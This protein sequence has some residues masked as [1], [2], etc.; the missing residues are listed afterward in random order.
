MKINELSV[1]VQLPF[2]VAELLTQN[3][4][5][6]V[7]NTSEEL[8]EAAMG[9]STTN[10]YRVGY[11]VPGKGYIE[12]AVVHKVENGISANYI[13]PYMRRRDPNTMVIGDDQP[14][15][16]IRYKEKYGCEFGPVRDESF[17]WLK[18]QE[19]ALFFF[20]AGTQNIGVGGMAIVPANAG[21]FAFGLS[22][23]Q[24]IL[25]ADNLPED[26]KVESVIYVIPPFRHTYFDG[27]QVVVHNRKEDLYELFCYNLYPGPSA[28]KGVYGVLLNRGEKENW[29][30][31]H[32]SAVQTTSAYDN[33]TTFMHEGASGGGKSEMHQHIIREPNGQ[34]SIG[35]NLVTGERRLITIP[36]FSEIHPVCDDMAFCHPS[37]QKSKKKLWIQDAEN[38]WFIRTDSI[39]NYGDDPTL[40][41]VIINNEK[42]LFFLNM[43]TKPG[44]IALP[45]K[46]IEDEPGKKCPNPRV[47]VP[48]DIIPAHVDGAV[49]VDVRS[50]GVRTPP[51]SAKDP[52]Y[53]I[54]GL[55][56]VLPPALA[57][58]WRLVSPRGYGNPSIVSNDGGIG[59]E[60]VGSYWPFA[61]GKM[62]EHANMLLEQIANTPKTNFVITPNQH[63]GVWKVGFKPQL[64]MRE[65]LT[66]RGNVKFSSDQ[67]QPA[68]CPLLGYEFKYLSIEGAKIPSRFLRVYGQNEVGEKGYEEGAKIL[69]DFFKSEI[70]KFLQPDLS[71]LGRT[72]IETCLN[73]GTIE[74]YLKLIPMR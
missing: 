2:E 17:E 31:T 51:C 26:F 23:L 5:F 41:K 28:K 65:Y 64:L 14:T 70:K 49:G 25:P 34:V 29:I 39:F 72:I 24:E 9:G 52:S 30:T 19:L 56:H 3:P 67:I 61:T 20:N 59:S 15:D 63:I 11:D 7:Y 38:G 73:D 74:D 10:E 40:E 12:E 57:W 55:F 48:R 32:C 58:L 47:V 68:K 46:H 6:T 44:G 16:K 4:N 60:G 22:M 62:V 1:A 13:E 8:A 43:E 35:T 71:D 27:K 66:R 69:T 42:P 36:I 33:V 54:L 50:F 45:W 21:F 18:K 37:I 53:G